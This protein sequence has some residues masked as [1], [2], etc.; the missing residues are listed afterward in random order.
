MQAE[1]HSMTDQSD[2]KGQTGALEGN[3][4]LSVMGME[5]LLS[6]WE[7]SAQIGLD[8]GEN[9]LERESRGKVQFDSCQSFTDSGPYFEKA[10]LQGVILSLG[11]LGPL[12]AFL[13][14]GMEEHIGG[15]VQEEAELVGL[16]TVTGG[17]V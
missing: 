17:S 15:A 8:G 16:E 2:D 9:V 5:D 4:V 13:G 11:P 6:L 3:V 1:R 10:V 14:Q 7:G 12:E